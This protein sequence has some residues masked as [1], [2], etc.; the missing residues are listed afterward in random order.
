[1]FLFPHYEYSELN[2]EVLDRIRA[3]I[4]ELRDTIEP[5]WPYSVTGVRS[6]DELRETVKQQEIIINLLLKH[7]SLEF[8]DKHTEP[9]EALLRSID[10]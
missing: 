1:M 8:V 9:K 10:D 4:R 3:E 7:L 2:I 6:L 5:T